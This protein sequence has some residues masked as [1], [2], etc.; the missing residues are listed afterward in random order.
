MGNKESKQA[1]PLTANEIREKIL[2]EVN[3][4]KKSF[5]RDKIRMQIEMKVAR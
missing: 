1:A 2:K 4:K 3:D 5:D